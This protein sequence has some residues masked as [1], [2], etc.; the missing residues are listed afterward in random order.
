MLGNCWL[1]RHLA[2][3]IPYYCWKCIRYYWIQFALL[4]L[5]YFW[6]FRFQT[7]DVPDYYT[8]RWVVQF[9]SVSDC[10]QK[11]LLYQVQIVSRRRLLRNIQRLNFTGICPDNHPSL[12][13]GHGFKSTTK[14]GYSQ[15][16]ICVPNSISRANWRSEAETGDE[17]KY[18]CF[19]DSFIHHL[20]RSLS[21]YCM[22]QLNNQ[23]LDLFNKLSVSALCSLILGFP[24]RESQA[25]QGIEFE[26]IPS[27]SVSDQ[28]TDN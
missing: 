4:S 9:H 12:I 1:V 16:S 15:E 21:F 3:S 20:N 23:R 27:F 22:E 24:S 11:F 7:E 17:Y 8:N 26:F 18:F 6:N 10:Q 14:V 5:K 19:H 13:Q 2:L 25:S 28:L